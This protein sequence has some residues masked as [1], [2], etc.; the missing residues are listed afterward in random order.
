L[1]R[2]ARVRRGRARQLTRSVVGLAA[3]SAPLLDG[4]GADQGQEGFL[5]AFVGDRRIGILADA[6]VLQVAHAATPQAG[7]ELLDVAVLEGRRG[8]EQGTREGGRAGEDAVDH[9]GVEVEIQVES[10]AE[11][12]GEDDRAG[13]RVSSG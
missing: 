3:V 2:G 12:L 8:M 7:G 13:A 6:A 4:S 9:E 10:A 1:A 5:G 11:A